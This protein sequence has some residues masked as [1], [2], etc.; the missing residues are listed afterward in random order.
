MDEA[1]DKATKLQDT[2][3]DLGSK[4]D[5]EILRSAFATS[6]SESPAPS[7]KRASKSFMPSWP[8]KTYR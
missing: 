1:P 5:E 4:S 6:A 7:S 8:S 2:A 3:P